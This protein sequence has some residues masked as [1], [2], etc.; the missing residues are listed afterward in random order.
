MKKWCIA[1]MLVLLLAGCGDQPVMETVAD[2]PVL[3]PVIFVLFQ[4]ENAVKD[5]LFS[6]I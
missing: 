2:E 6:L 3:A 4:T 1:A 5:I